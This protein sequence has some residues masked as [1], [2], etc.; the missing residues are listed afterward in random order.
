MKSNFR[1]NT[2]ASVFCASVTIAALTIST[3][4]AAEQFQSRHSRTQTFTDYARVI[5]VDPIYKQVTL[6]KPYEECRT[7]YQ[8]QTTTYDDHDGYQHKRRRSSTGQTI[9]GGLV[10]G[11]IGNQLGSHSGSKKGR[12]GGTIAG[13]IIGSAIANESPR[14]HRRQSISKH[15]RPQVIQTTPVQHCTTHV[16]TVYEQQLKGYKVTYRYQ[17]QQYTTRMKRDPGSRIPVQI[18][19]KPLRG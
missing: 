7:E 16:E 15:R 4:A 3:N 1:P 17:G 13:A 10:G 6:Q 8:S 12:V 2:V 9:I 19:I 11:V 14:R 18:S 5:D